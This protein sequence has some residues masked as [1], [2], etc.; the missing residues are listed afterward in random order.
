MQ[1]YYYSTEFQ[2]RIRFDKDIGVFYF[3]NGDNKEQKFNLTPEI[4]SITIKENNKLSKEQYE[5][6][7]SSVLYEKIISKN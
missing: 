7:L 4:L 2:I 3:R 5:N 1:Y 6:E